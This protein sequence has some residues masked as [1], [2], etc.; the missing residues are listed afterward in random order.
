MGGRGKGWARCSE[1]CACTNYP[2]WMARQ[3]AAA[4]FQSN[5]RPRSCTARPASLRATVIPTA[6][7]CWVGQ[8]AALAGEGVVKVQAPHDASTRSGNVPCLHLRGGGC[9]PLTLSPFVLLK[10][11][12]LPSAGL[13][14][15]PLYI[16]LCINTRRQ[17]GAH[18]APQQLRG[19]AAFG[20]SGVRHRGYHAQSTIC[21]CEERVRRGMSSC[22]GWGGGGYVNARE[23]LD[24]WCGQHASAP[25]HGAHMRTGAHTHAHAQTQGTAHTH[26]CARTHTHTH[27]HAHAHI[28]LRSCTPAGVQPRHQRQRNPFRPRPQHAVQHLQQPPRHPQAH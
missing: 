6:T 4:H 5:R 14:H 18:A 23:G 20:Q 8:A 25:V 27:A 15:F 16:C 22:W 1:A 10:L 7:V 26:V 12:R 13:V 17:A 3:P 2:L 21:S 11:P 28:R 9:V 19:C 24:S